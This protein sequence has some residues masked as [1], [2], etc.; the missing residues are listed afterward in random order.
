MKLQ[1]LRYFLTVCEERSV[2]RAARKLYVSQPTISVAIRELERE[3]DVT[4]L[5]REEPGFALT[6]AGETFLEQSRVI[7]RDVDKLGKSM[8]VYRRST[9]EIRLGVPTMAGAYILPILLP[10]YRRLHAS[11]ELK[12]TEGGSL[13]LFDQLRRGEL[14]FAIVTD[15]E[16]PEYDSVT[17]YQSETLFYI[18]RDDPLSSEP[19]LTFRMLDGVPLVVFSREKYAMND[20]IAR[21]FAA[22]D[23]VMNVFCETT[24]V[25]NMYQMISTHR[26][27]GFIS[28]QLSLTVPDAV[29]VPFRPPL[30][31]DVRLLWK[32]GRRFS[33]DMHVI[34]NICTYFS[35]AG[36]Q[37]RQ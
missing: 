12:I 21:R 27:G 25:M 1:Q 7:L 30:L 35:D 13:W 10:A 14:D 15:L 22:E 23:A 31:S 26:A 11:A 34:R 29:G 8:G 18:H 33:D 9:P 3:F 16:D 32:K 17:L 2:N 20:R 4:L 5:N 19:F 6:E 36:E 28:R 37:N 24:Q